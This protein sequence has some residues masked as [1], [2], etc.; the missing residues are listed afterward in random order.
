MAPVKFTGAA[1]KQ[2]EGALNQRVSKA[3]LFLNIYCYML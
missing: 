1:S 2:A 3:C